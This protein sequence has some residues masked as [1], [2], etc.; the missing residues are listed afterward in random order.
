MKWLRE[1]ETQLLSLQWFNI[2][3]KPTI[4]Y[5]VHTTITDTT[6]YWKVVQVLPMIR[7]RNKCITFSYPKD[8]SL[9]LDFPF[10]PSFK[11][12]LF[13]WVQFFFF[14]NAYWS[15]SCMLQQSRAAVQPPLELRVVAA[16]ACEDTLGTYSTSTR[17]GEM[18]RGGEPQARG[19]SEGLQATCC[20]RHLAPTH[21]SPNYFSNDPPKRQKNK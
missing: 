4:C 13:F 1:T 6:C 21:V 5:L 15:T 18:R 19:G 2:P 3:L 16:C 9:Q 8:V 17:I 12:F 7:V 11:L 10:I 20:L 14:F